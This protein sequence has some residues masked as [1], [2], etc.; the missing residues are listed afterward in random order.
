[1]KRI[2]GL[3]RRGRAL[4]ALAAFLGT[5]GVASAQ[6][7]PQYSEP[8]HVGVA[9]CASAPCHGSARASGGRV[10]QNEHTIWFRAKKHSLAYKVLEGELSQSIRR[11]LGLQ[12]PAHESPLCLNC[13]SDYAANRESTHSLEDGV[14]CEA[15]HGGAKSWLTTHTAATRMHRDNVRRGLYP[16]DNLVAR[17]R[18][19]LS[20]HFGDD[21]KLVD[22]RMMGAGHPRLRFELDLYHYEQPPHYEVDDDY[23]A[24]GKADHDPVRV[25]AI[26]QAVMVAD[27]LSVIADPERNKR[28]IWPEFAVLDCYDCHHTIGKFRRPARGSTGLRTHPGTPRLNDSAFLMLGQV[29]GAVD[30]D[31]AERLRQGT[32]KLHAAMSRGVGNRA[33]LAAELRRVVQTTIPKIQAWKID[34]ASVRKIAV[35]LID[36]GL[37]REYRDYTGAEQAMAAIYSL[38]DTLCRLRSCSPVQQDAIETSF[39]NLEAALVEPPAFRSADFVAGLEAVRQSLP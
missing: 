1:M 8:A 39:E 13:H 5:S 34:A 37:G 29:L 11:N 4:C 7:L 32:R 17:A 36:A 30:P 35:G 33:T 38:A 27:Q 28:G 31:G 14:G 10:G 19:C 20:C 24:R 22:H 25:W 6:V 26:G 2:P 9:E 12:Q 15:C 16:T 21:K 3:G 18:L 23:V